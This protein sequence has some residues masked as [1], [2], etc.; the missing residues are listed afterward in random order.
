M[1]VLSLKSSPD[2]YGKAEQTEQ[3]CPVIQGQLPKKITLAE[4]AGRTG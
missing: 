1:D 4:R 3:P 2:G